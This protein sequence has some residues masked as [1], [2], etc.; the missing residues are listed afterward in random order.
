MATNDILIQYSDNTL[1]DIIIL[2]DLPFA[3]YLTK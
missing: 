3:I 2:D 1:L